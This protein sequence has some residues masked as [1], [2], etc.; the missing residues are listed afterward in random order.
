ML[1]LLIALVV[2]S[3]LGVAVTGI[4][5]RG[6]QTRRDNVLSGQAQAYGNLVLEDYK[7]LWADAE[8]YRVGN[9]PASLPNLPAG[10]EGD[11][12]DTLN[13]SD[14]C[15]DVDGS[16]VDCEDGVAPPLRRVRV[17][18]F[19]REGKVRADLITEIGNPRP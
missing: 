3:I 15:V 11:D 4:F 2:F 5:V 8:A 7:Q 17:Q 16:G 19:D 14:T 13:I 9:G 1:E 6:M 12:I 10:F 18:L